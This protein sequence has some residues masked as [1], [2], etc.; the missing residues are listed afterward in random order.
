L[1]I[2]N[3]NKSFNDIILY[4][5]FSLTL[6]QGQ[7]SCLLGPSGCGKTSLLNIMARLMPCEGGTLEVPHRVSYVFQEPRLL[8]WLS[9]KANLIYAQDRTLTSHKRK[10]RAMDMME[11]VGLS[12]SEDKYPRELSGGMA[13]RV[14]LARALL[15]D[16]DLMLMD[17][18]LASLD[19]ELKES[20][21]SLL[22][23]QLQ[24][25][26]ALLVTHDYFTARMLSDSVFVLSNPPVRANRIDKSQLQTI[27]DD[28]NSK[29]PSQKEI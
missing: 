24:G 28:I 27:L 1:R 4:R 25:K 19:Q 17:E 26:T 29:E 14:G 3:L 13:R 21:I 12:G 11:R 18:P 9:V 23:E 5:D 8:P 10:D 16:Y 7:I 15:A 20:L 6:P 2:E 22:K